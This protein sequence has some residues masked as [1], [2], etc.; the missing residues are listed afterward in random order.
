VLEIDP[1]ARHHGLVK[2]ETRLGTV[3]VD[4]FTNRMIVRPLR[5]AGVQ[6]IEDGGFRLLEIRQFKD[7]FG[8]ELTFFVGHPCSVHDAAKP[9][10]ASRA[11]WPVSAATPLPSL[12]SDCMLHGT[13]AAPSRREPHH[14]RWDTIRFF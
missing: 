11:R 9:P 3:P 7:G 2:G 8:G 4:K 12:D 10:E 14:S 1:V 5:A 6:T 13:I